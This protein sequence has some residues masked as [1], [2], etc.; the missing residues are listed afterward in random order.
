MRDG[1]SHT[2]ANDHKDGCGR[3][4]RCR[5][6][7][8]QELDRD[9]PFVVDGL[10]S[11]PCCEQL[12]EDTSKAAPVG[13]DRLAL[14]AIDLGECR[15]RVALGNKGTRVIE[16]CPLGRVHDDRVGERAREGGW[17]RCIPTR[18]LRGGSGRVDTSAAPDGHL[19]DFDRVQRAR[20][21]FD[22]TCDERAREATKPQ[23][24]AV[25]QPVG[26]LGELRDTGIRQRLVGAVDDDG[27][28]R[29]LLQHRPRGGRPAGSSPGIDR[30][31]AEETL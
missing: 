9:E 31:A 15:Q 8:E 12:G 19:V 7:F 25:G 2:V 28:R 11:A 23:L 29:V 10:G 17:R 22:I 14:R 26:E 4:D 13:V 24:E 27:R 3:R 21:R 1:Q 6:A 5:D 18:D 20:G 30:V 16:P